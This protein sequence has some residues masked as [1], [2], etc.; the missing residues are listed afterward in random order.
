MQRCLTAW[1]TVQ[2]GSVH[3]QCPWAQHQ[4]NKRLVDLWNTFH[5]SFHLFFVFYV[6]SLVFSVLWFGVIGFFIVVGFCVDPRKTSSHFVEA[7]GDPKKEQRTFN[8]NRRSP[9]NTVFLIH[10]IGERVEACMQII[11]LCR[12]RIFIRI[13]VSLVKK[14][15]AAPSPALLKEKN[16]TKSK[17]DLVPTLPTMQLPTV[18]FQIQVCVLATEAC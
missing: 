9:W 12:K 5:E 14:K 4:F 8:E 13:N 15:K 7:N 16:K 10:S 18:Q 2:R 3:D 6:A 11:E 17:L 1:V